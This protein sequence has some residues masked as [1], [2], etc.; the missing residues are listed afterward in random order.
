MLPLHQA[1]KTL[2]ILQDGE[3]PPRGTIQAVLV[4]KEPS[5]LE[6]IGFPVDEV[7]AMS[8]EF[9][10]EKGLLQIE[11]IVPRGPA[12]QKLMQG[13]VLALADGKPVSDFDALT[14]ILDS[15]VGQSITIVAYR[16]NQQ[17]EVSVSVHNLFQLNPTQ[18]VKIGYGHPD[19]FS[20]TILHEVSLNTASVK[21][22]PVEGIM[23]ADANRL[24]AHARIS[25]GDIITHINRKPTR[26][27]SELLDILPKLRESESI[28]FTT[29]SMDAPTKPHTSVLP[30]WSTGFP[31]DLM[32]RDRASGY[33]STTRILPETSSSILEQQP[34]V[35]PGRLPQQ[36]AHLNRA[37]SSIVKVAFTSIAPVSLHH[38]RLHG[39]YGFVASKEH[40]LVVCDKVAVPTTVGEVMII[41]ADTISIPATAAYIDP[42]SCFV[43]LKYDVSL[44]TPD[45]VEEAMFYNFDQRSKPVPGDTVF[46]LSK[47][48]RFTTAVHETRISARCPISMDQIDPERRHIL[49]TEDIVPTDATPSPNSILMCNTSGDVCGFWTRYS[50]S[51]SCGEGFTTLF[52]SDVSTVAPIINALK[53]GAHPVRATFNAEFSP[54]S[55]LDARAYGL[56]TAR[57]AELMVNGDSRMV[58]AVART[59]TRVELTVDPNGTVDDS[60]LRVDD[61]VLKLDGKYVH[62]ISEIA[63]FYDQMPA[64]LLILRDGQEVALTKPTLK[65]HP[66]DMPDKVVFWSGMCIRELTEEIRSHGNW[67]TS[68][69]YLG[70][71]TAAAPANH[72]HR[73]Q[74]IT[75][76]NG[77]SIDNIDDFVLVIKR[78]VGKAAVERF[79]RDMTGPPPQQLVRIQLVD[80]RGN[81]SNQH[82]TLDGYHYPAMMIKTDSNGKWVQE[83][84]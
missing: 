6:R 73:P 3:L 60:L 53:K 1:K 67:P 29:I 4:R 65:I 35:I 78:T 66:A 80:E 5:E 16:D 10:K 57:I 75:C 11:S 71:I 74:V 12:F 54:I 42:A 70:R 31:M 72:I 83:M 50:R 15:C 8:G 58:F 61:I 7:I 82:I 46:L 69:V 33:W 52:L 2:A 64:S 25:R 23:V 62:S 34:S 68:G 19:T 30:H 45:A 37:H 44:L 77:I 17:F 55:L 13:D 49:N 47:V 63:V 21:C 9:R 14:D 81:V 40:G 26:T 48:D 43:V 79:A 32:T 84:L 24:F 22:L 51:D 38:T 20:T 41:V 59:G 56:S 27:M 36:Y 28:L 76:V 18:L 39:G